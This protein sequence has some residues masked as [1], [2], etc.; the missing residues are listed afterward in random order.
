MSNLV[1]I[2]NEQLSQ[3]A[4]AKFSAEQFIILPENWT[5]KS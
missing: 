3:N 5:K 1:D 4:Y 2:S